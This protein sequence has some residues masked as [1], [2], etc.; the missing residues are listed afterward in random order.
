MCD[1]VTVQ[2]NLTKVE[3]DKTAQIFQDNLF[4]SIRQQRD[5]RHKSVMLTIFRFLQIKPPSG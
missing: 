3:D 2:D 1:T 4:T 5:T